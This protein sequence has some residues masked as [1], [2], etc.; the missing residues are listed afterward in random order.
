MLAKFVNVQGDYILPEIFIFGRLDETFDYGNTAVFVGF[1]VAR[2]S[3]DS[4]LTP[5]PELGIIELPTS[6]TD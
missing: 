5:C 1:A 3:A 6:I 4:F 2:F